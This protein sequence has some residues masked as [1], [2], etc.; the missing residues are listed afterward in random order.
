MGRLLIASIT[1][2][3]CTFDR[4]GIAGDVAPPDAAEVDP[5]A[6][7]EVAAG[8]RHTCARRGDGSIL[9]WG[10]NALGALGG[11]S[12][13]TCPATGFGCSPSPALVEGLAP[14]ADLALG[15][16]HT[17]GVAFD[18]RI[19]CWGDNAAGQFGG[20]P[21]GS[22]EPVVIESRNGAIELV[23]GTTYTCGRDG[24]DA[25]WCSCANSSGELG[26]GTTEPSPEPV[27]IPGVTAR[28][29]AG[30]ARGVCAIRADDRRVMCWGSN[31]LGQLDA[32][33]VGQ[34]VL[35]PVPVV[36]VPETSQVVAGQRHACAIAADGTA[37]CWGD[38]GD[39]QLGIGIV[40]SP[41]T[42]VL[43]NLPAP[44]ADLAAAGDHT[45][46]LR[47]G[48]VMCWGEGYGVAPVTAALPLPALEITAGGAHD[49]ARLED[50]SVWCWGDN[51]AG[52]L[53]DGTV[54]S[55]TV[56]VQSRICE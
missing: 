28:G 17:C 41:S 47:E 25:V 56:P 33:S 40:G 6:A 46:V 21:T 51:R 19:F 27:E 35:S 34:D 36:G 2:A 37:W 48:L 7:E 5:C 55:R 1:L 12:Q 24:G 45:C 16:G 52:Q 8:A 11:P 39:G 9:C 30:G 43:V 49:C 31:D 26:I 23:A 22:V 3:G 44:L 14:V 32:T 54:D 13:T 20:G 38:N 29:L 18:R 15:D 4:A 53:G 10:D 50:R 42:A